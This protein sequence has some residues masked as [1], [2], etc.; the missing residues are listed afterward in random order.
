MRKHARMVERVARELLIHRAEGNE[1]VTMVGR[2]VWD[3][4]ETYITQA[5][6]RQSFKEQRLASLHKNK[7]SASLARFWART[8]G[9]SGALAWAVHDLGWHAREFFINPPAAMMTHFQNGDINEG[10]INAGRPDARTSYRFLMEVLEATLKAAEKRGIKPIGFRCIESN[11]G[12]AAHMNLISAFSSGEDGDTFTELLWSK[13][14]SV[15]RKKYAACMSRPIPLRS[16]FGVREPALSTPIVSRGVSPDELV[17]QV[18]YARKGCTL[19]NADRLFCKLHG[20]RQFDV[21]G[22]RDAGKWDFFR[23]LNPTLM[24]SESVP[25]R[26]R[27]LYA[28]TVRG[29]YRSWL[30]LTDLR[31]PE[32]LRGCS[33]DGQMRECLLLE[34]DLGQRVLLIHSSTYPPE[35]IR[36][37]RGGLSIVNLTPSVGRST[38]CEFSFA[39]RS[40]QALRAARSA[41]GR[42]PPS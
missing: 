24:Q 18:N 33:N 19:A 7:E 27:G 25:A 39:S 4:R 14:Y 22:V 15:V 26:V 28:A 3:R 8:D 42:K 10:W 30:R 17:Q 37:D 32:H 16:G 1:R 35:Q 38:R 2:E 34:F 23:S 41:A 6:R 12:G 5:L 13:Y 36:I 11:R 9:E 40:S 31:T 20:L 29:D 21:I